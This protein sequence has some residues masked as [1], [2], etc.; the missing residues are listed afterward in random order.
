M[1]Y[2]YYSNTTKY[3]EKKIP[4]RLYKNPS[5]HNKKRHISK[6][7]H[8]VQPVQPTQPTKGNH[9]LLIIANYKILNYDTERSQQRETKKWSQMIAKGDDAGGFSEALLRM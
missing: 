2:Q 1:I 8:R 9:E 5:F 7:W 6:L 3:N 4:S